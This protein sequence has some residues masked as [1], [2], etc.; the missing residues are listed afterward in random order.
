MF[1]IVELHSGESSSWHYI[2]RREHVRRALQHRHQSATER[3]RRLYRRCVDFDQRRSDVVQHCRVVVQQRIEFRV[4]TRRND[5]VD[6]VTT[7]T[8]TTTTMKQYNRISARC[9][10]TQQSSTYVYRRPVA[11]E[12]LVNTKARCRTTLPVV[13]VRATMPDV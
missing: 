9:L 6:R 13:H 2:E 8:T 12:E 4:E 1:I 3:N 5:C 7:I 11:R 10:K